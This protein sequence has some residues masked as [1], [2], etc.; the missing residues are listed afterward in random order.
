MSQSDANE[1]VIEIS[2]ELVTQ[3]APEELILFRATS[4]AFVQNPKRVLARADARDEM[5]GFGLGE[6]VALFTPAILAVA[7][8]V[9]NFLITE[10]AKA[11]RTEG[12]SLIQETVRKLVKSLR[13]P[14]ETQDDQHP[15]LTTAQLAQVR[16]IALQQ[17]RQMKLSDTR[18]NVLA[19]AIVGSLAVMI[20]V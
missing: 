3:L 19:D 1:I 2:R 8:A 9:V 5:L 6:T 18:A 13:S 11:A 14:V 20:G 10:V 17:A 7:S 16:A 4:Q 12:A 15:G